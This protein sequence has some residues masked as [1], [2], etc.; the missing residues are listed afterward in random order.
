MSFSTSCA[1]WQATKDYELSVSAHQIVQVLHRCDSPRRPDSSH[2]QTGMDK[3]EPVDNQGTLSKQTAKL[4]PNAPGEWALIRV[5][6]HGSTVT[7][8]N[9][10]NSTL[11]S[12]IKE[13]FIPSRLIGAPSGR[14]RR[15]QPNVQTGSSRRPSAAVRKWLPVGETRRTG[16]T[17]PGKR[18]SKADLTQ[19][20]VCFTK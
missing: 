1:W 5:L 12:P 4:D 8:S 18:G 20:Q 19:P 2:L 17:H 10:N 14:P 6:V 11:Q 3:T 13:G 15:R 7:G 9:N 16:P